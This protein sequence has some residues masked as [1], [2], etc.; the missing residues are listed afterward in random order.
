MDDAIKVVQ[1]GP[2]R[3]HQVFDG[4]VNALKW[5]F[6]SFPQEAKDKVSVKKLNVGEGNCVLKK[7]V[8]M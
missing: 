1:G 2:E 3:K 5:I 8:L 7:E 6:T 4:T